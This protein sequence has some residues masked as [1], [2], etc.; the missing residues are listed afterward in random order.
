MSMTD[1][2]WRAAIDTELC[3]LAEQLE[4]GC[5]IAPSRRWQLEGFIAAAQADGIGPAELLRW[6]EPHRSAYIEVEIDGARNSLRFDFR[7]KRAPVYPS[8]PS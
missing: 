8:A 7:Q 6:C 4:R 2:Q 1:T 5:D 3:A